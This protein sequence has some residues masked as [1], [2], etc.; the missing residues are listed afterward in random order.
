M[1]VF[2]KGIQV[3]CKEVVEREEV[4]S[5]VDEGERKVLR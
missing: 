2:D 5:G 3:S 4:R 1:Q